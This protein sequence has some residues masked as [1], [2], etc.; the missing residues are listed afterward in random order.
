MAIR[1]GGLLRSTIRAILP[2]T[3]S[4]SAIL[5]SLSR[6]TAITSVGTWGI[7]VLTAGA[8]CGVGETDA[9]AV[10]QGLGPAAVPRL[11]AVAGPG[12]S[13]LP[14]PGFARMSAARRS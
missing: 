13:A 9:A 6:V 4:I 7:G 1:P 8:R 12:L 3:G 2:V 10:G 14:G 11:T 5:F